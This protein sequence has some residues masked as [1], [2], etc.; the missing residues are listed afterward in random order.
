MF[1]LSHKLWRLF[2]F[3][4]SH[5]LWRLFAFLLSSIVFSCGFACL[6][7][8]ISEYTHMYFY[9]C[10]F[11]YFGISTTCSSRNT[12]ASCIVARRKRSTNDIQFTTRSE[13]E[14]LESLGLELLGLVL[15]AMIDVA[16]GSRAS[17]M[18]SSST[19]FS[20]ACVC[21]LEREIAC[22][23]VCVESISVGV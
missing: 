7:L 8:I 19:S 2:V 9:I 21:G 5:K 6:S 4:L 15:V 13:E 1:L 16:D 3:L 11:L 23:R 12:S 20:K 14:G 17:C 22:A 10:I 18:S